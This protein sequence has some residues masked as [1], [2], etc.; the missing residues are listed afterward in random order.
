MKKKIF[1]VVGIGI[2]PF[3]LSVAALLPADRLS[4]Q[5]LEA[6]PDFQWHPGML[7]PE[8]TIQVSYLKDLV[9]PAN[10]TSPYSFL[11]FLFDQ[12]RFYH[13]LNANFQRTSREE[14]NQ[15]LQWACSKI[16]NLNFGC[17]VESVNLQNDLFRIDTQKSVL[18]AKN[19][20][21]GTGLTPYV[22]PCA[23]HHL[24]QQT[25]F[26]SKD[27][28]T[29]A[30]NLKGKRVVVIGGGQSGAEIV[31]HLL[32]TSDQIPKK[33]SWI[34]RR[35]NFLPLDESPFTNEFFTPA[36][37][38]FFNNLSASD[39]SRILNEQ[40]MASDGIAPPLLEQLYQKVYKRCFIEKNNG[41]SY[42]FMPHR[43]LKGLHPTHGKWTISLENKS[44][45]TWESTEADFVILCTGYTKSLPPYLT[46]LVGRISK[47][48][49]GFDVRPDFSVVWDGPS[50][51][52]IYIQNGARHTHG[53]ADPNLSLMAWRSAT[54]IN[55]LV[56]TQVYKVPENNPS[57]IT[58]TT[59][60][61]GV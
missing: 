14:F 23:A 22:P 26:H 52:R 57:L 20:I 18:H 43:D 61:N 40:K 46:P 54:I 11:S 1:D 32:S 5:F 48:A 13:F 60:E 19:I 21:L 45:R 58:W 47:C 25:V 8:S 55:S 35:L 12:D 3:N 51:R 50:H 56:G 49:G 17:H 9:T 7:F 4:S 44:S 41:D 2:G 34:S 24:G 39:R 27:F 15:Y 30:P 31:L 36:Y 16:P 37:V 28:L 42:S 6:R 33:I 29:R 59:P 53:V 10:P 38:S